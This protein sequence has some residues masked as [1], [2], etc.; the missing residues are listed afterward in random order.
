MSLR[1]DIVSFWFWGYRGNL[2]T[3]LQAPVVHLFSDILGDTS[4]K[5]V[6]ETV[7]GQWIQIDLALKMRKKMRMKMWSAQVVCC[8]Q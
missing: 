8:I 5:T 4:F 7:S 1:N 3:E 2:R 6:S